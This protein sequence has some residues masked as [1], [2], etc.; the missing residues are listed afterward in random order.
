MPSLKK[1]TITRY[2]DDNGKQVRKL[3]PG[4][5]K[6]TTK[7][8]KWY[9]Q[10]NDEHGLSKVVPLSTDKSAAQVML[11]KLVAKAQRRIAG[12]HDPF[13]EHQSKPLTE[14]VDEYES[15]LLGKGDTEKHVKQ[16][17]TRIRKLI[18]G[19]GFL[20][21]S[22]LEA[23]KAV[24]WLSECRRTKKRFS[25]RTSNF[26]QEGIKT[27][28]NWLVEHERIRKN[29][30]ARLKRLKVDSDKRHD[31]RSLSDDEFAR[32]VA[33]AE[34]GKTIEGI[35]GVDRSMLYI[36]AAWTGLRRRELAS[37]NRRSLKLDEESPVVIVE[38]GYA[39]NGR[40]D[41][42]PLH[43]TVVERI[44]NW[45]ESKR[46]GN[47]EPLF[48]L[49]TAS[50]FYRKTAVMMRRDLAAARLAWIEESTDD[51][52]RKKREASDFLTYQNEDGLFADFHANRHTFI[53]RLGRS[54][55]PMA[56]A[57]RL[58]RHSDPRLT[59]N[60]Y[61]HIDEGVKAEAIASLDGL[62]DSGNEKS[63]D[64]RD[65]IVALEV[66]LTGT[67]SGQRKSS[68]V[69]ASKIGQTECLS[70]NSL[71]EETLVKFCHLMTAPDKV[72]PTGFEPV[73]FGFVDRC[74]IQLSYGC[75]R[76]YFTMY[77]RLRKV[78]ST[79]NSL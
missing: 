60:V 53:T 59:A 18:Q 47:D 36:M 71:S 23:P 66:A 76:P 64:D 41:Q 29:P 55:V 51:A 56:T 30:F 10:Y 32:L 34:G 4:A 20:Q 46:L 17:A 37:L 19:C 27:F 14:H 6:V 70:P 78:R 22:D 74:S 50:G 48:V 33:A 15:Y 38:A 9:G 44:K 25:A 58:A 11:N 40:K 13:E 69:N 63:A 24:S 1:K 12:D 73:T 52:V 26:Y 79:H 2:L 21:L 35:S 8:R 45:L 57:Q 42:I 49:K 62:R 72:H 28:A 54:N 16:T 31:R 3:S 75:A 7:S 67:N 43:D 39:K 68:A 77:W 5:K 61:T 65:E